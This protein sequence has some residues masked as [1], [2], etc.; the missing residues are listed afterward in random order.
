M[1]SLPKSQSKTGSASFE[2]P[3]AYFCL[4]VLLLAGGPGRF[5]LDRRIFGP[6]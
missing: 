1:P 2:L 6:R 3:A 5:S 4:A